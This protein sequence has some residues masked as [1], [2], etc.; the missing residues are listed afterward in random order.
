MWITMFKMWI[1]FIKMWISMAI[2]WITRYFYVDKWGKMW[3]TMWI[4]GEIVKFLYKVSKSF[5][6]SQKHVKQKYLT[7]NLKK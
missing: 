7:I 5:V 6:N 2:M 3:I 4:S 1:T